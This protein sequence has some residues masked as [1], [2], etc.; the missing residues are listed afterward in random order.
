[1]STDDSVSLPRMYL[2]HILKLERLMGRAEGHQDTAERCLKV[3][4]RF[5]DVGHAE[6]AATMRHL[7]RTLNRSVRRLTAR[8][9]AM[10][11]EAALLARVAT[12]P[13]GPA[14]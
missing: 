3:A 11:E 5:E 1:M 14:N 2:D 12:G 4:S 6:E 13:T 7:A 8:A 9:E 10:N